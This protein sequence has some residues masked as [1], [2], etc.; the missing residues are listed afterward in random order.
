MI[1]RVDDDLI[2]RVMRRSLLDLRL[3][4]SELDG[5]RY[6]AAGVPWYATLFGRDS[7]IAALQT[8]AFDADIA[9]DTLRLLA[10]HLG[11]RMDDEHDEEP[12]KVLHELRQDELAAAGLTP[13]AR[14]YGTVDAT[15]LFLCLL[16]STRTGPGRSSRSTS[17]VRTSSVPSAG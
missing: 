5:H 8:V 7:I 4:A 6:Y 1:E 17:C 2:E 11:L 9:A 14:Y 16:G 3:L 10:A 15:T 13:F 12:G